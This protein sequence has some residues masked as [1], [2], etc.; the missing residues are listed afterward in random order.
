MK[1]AITSRQTTSF[2]CAL[3]SV[4]DGRLCIGFVL[5]H[6]RGSQAST[7]F[8]GI[9]AKCPRRMTRVTPPRR[10]AS[11]EENVKCRL[12]KPRLV[13]PQT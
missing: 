6:Y 9:P 10:S 13:F 8:A 2:S 12:L 3:L 11:K 7:S 4:Y 5:R 1:A